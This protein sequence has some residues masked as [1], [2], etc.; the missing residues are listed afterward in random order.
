MSPFK[1]FHSDTSN[2]SK[3]AVLSSLKNY[4]TV[5]LNTLLPKVFSGWIRDG[6]GLLHG[7]IFFSCVIL[8]VPALPPGA[9]QAVT[10]PFCCKFCQEIVKAQSFIII[11]KGYFCLDIDELYF[12]HIAAK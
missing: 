11:Q 3:S 8:T 9:L 6:T 2:N 1:S 5:T 7:G 4:F 10:L 12:Y